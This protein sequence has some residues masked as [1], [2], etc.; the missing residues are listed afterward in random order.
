MTDETINSLCTAGKS[1]PGCQLKNLT[2]SEQ[3]LLKRREAQKELGGL[4]KISDIIASP[5]VFEYRNKADALFLKTKIKTYAGE[6]TALRTAT[7]PR[8]KIAPYTPKRRTRFLTT[9]RFF[10]KALK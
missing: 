8:R 10:S 1:C 7:A 6:F 3:L 4:C 9:L 5:W 2:Y